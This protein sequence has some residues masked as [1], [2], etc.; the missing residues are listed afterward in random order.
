MSPAIKILQDYSAGKITWQVAEKEMRSLG[1]H[2]SADF[3]RHTNT[4]L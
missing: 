3:I 1:L 4:N 2:M